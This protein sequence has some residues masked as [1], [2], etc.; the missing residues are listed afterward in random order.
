MSSP[1]DPAGERLGQAVGGFGKRLRLVGTVGQ[2][3]RQIRKVDDKA[4]FLIRLQPRR[5]SVMTC[6]QTVFLSYRNP[7]HL[8]HSDDSTMYYCSIP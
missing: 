7:L 6:S 8:D 2:S 4:A 1:V 3:L 5:K